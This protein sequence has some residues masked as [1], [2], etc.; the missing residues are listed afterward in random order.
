MEGESCVG[1]C[2]K[3][4]IQGSAH[5]DGTGPTRVVFMITGEAP[6][7]R[8]G[9][10]RHTTRVVRDGGGHIQVAINERTLGREKLTLP[11]SGW[12]EISHDE[13]NE[14]ASDAV[15]ALGDRLGELRGAK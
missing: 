4:E 2:F 13:F 3:F 1:H 11:V 6:C 9:Y 8:G 5:G 12:N 7:G 15:T 14:F 10:W